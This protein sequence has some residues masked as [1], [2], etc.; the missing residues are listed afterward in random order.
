MNVLSENTLTHQDSISYLLT[1]ENEI[2][3]GT[4]RAKEKC[5]VCQGKFVEIKK[6]GF[7][8]QEHKTTPKR[9]FVDFFHGSQRFR[10]FSDRQGQVLD[11]YQRAVTLLGRVNSE[12]KDRTFDPTNYLKSE[13]EKY[14]ISTL[15][16]EFLKSKLTGIKPIAPSYVKHY[17]RYV[18]IAKEYFDTKDVRDVEELDIVNYYLYVSKEYKFGNKTLKN[19][20]D[21]FKT[22]LRYA[23]ATRKMIKTIPCFPCI[24]IPEPVTTWLTPETQ[25]VVFGHVPD[26]DKPIIAFIMLSGCRPGEARALKCR[27]VDLEHGTITICATFSGS[28]YR[29]KRKGQGAKNSI[30]PIHAEV[31]EFI[32]KRVES[33][34]PEAFV[35]VSNT[36]R[37][38]SA[39]KFYRM[40]GTVRD[41]SGLDKSIRLYDAARHSF[42]SQLINSNVSIYSVSRLMGHSSIKTTEKYLHSDMGK[43]KVDVSNLSLDRKV[44]KLDEAVTNKA[45]GKI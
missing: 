39:A 6:L 32:K 42:A 35:F 22:F 41:K 33:S 25:K 24:E 38:Y 16:E 1:E 19:C 9:F 21:I 3:K 12:I 5:P 34:L 17:R 28:V 10:L 26:E 11:S 37:H 4:I 13:L 14:Y 2:M 44:I 30:I 43:L 45:L 31:Y 40:W 18:G 20:L 36:G 7:I 8:C 15:L 29:Q 27:D 23:K